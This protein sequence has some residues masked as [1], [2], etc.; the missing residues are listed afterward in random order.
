MK[1]I[2]RLEKSKLRG[3]ATTAETTATMIGYFT[4][5]LRNLSLKGRIAVR[6][7]SLV[8]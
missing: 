3:T 2:A 6:E 5:I 7:L 8:Q 1:K 4:A